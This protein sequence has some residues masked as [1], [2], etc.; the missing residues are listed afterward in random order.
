MEISA[1][2]D[3]SLVPG[4]LVFIGDKL[5]RQLQD[6]ASTVLEIEGR[7]KLLADQPWTAES[8]RLRKIYT[9]PLNFLQAELLKRNRQQEE[10]RLERAIMVTIAGI[11]A[12]MR[13][14]G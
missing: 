12:G 13:N 2:Y 6:D 11:A 10:P 1:Y 14:T 7:E 5:R 9:D 3:K 4:E 8:I